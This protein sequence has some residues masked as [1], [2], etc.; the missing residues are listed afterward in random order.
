MYEIRN[1]RGH[2]EIYKDG[3][4]WCSAD[5]KREALKEIEEA[6]DEQCPLYFLRRKNDI[7]SICNKCH[8]RRNSYIFR[9][10]MGLI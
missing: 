10:C 5:T 4:F 9:S 8:N 7:C 1:V 3:V 6:E 2:Y